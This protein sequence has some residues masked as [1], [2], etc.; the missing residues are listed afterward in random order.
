MGQLLL[1]ASPYNIR[2]VKT[3]AELTRYL[4]DVNYNVAMPVFPRVEKPPIYHG[5]ASG[6]LFGYLRP[7]FDKEGLF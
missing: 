4:S 2:L 3:E 6:D 5:N 1:G 7:F